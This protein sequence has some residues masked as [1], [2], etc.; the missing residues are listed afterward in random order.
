M[1][2]EYHLLEDEIEVAV[3]ENHFEKMPIE[4]VLSIFSFL[5]AHDLLKVR[6]VCKEWCNL[7]DD[8]VIWKNLVLDDWNIHT[9]LEKT[10]KE[11]YIRI[12]DLF[13]FGLW[14][15]MSKWI[16]PA[17][18]DNEQKTTAEL[19]FH[20]K[21][22]VG[23]SLPILRSPILKS[24]PS[25]IRR[26]DS[27]SNA[28]EK[29]TQSKDVLYRVRGSGITINCANPSPFQI[30]G[31]RV[32]SDPTGCTFQWSKHFEK[33]TSVYDGKIDLATNTVSG[34][35]DYNDGSTHWKGVFFYTKM[36]RSIQ[37]KQRETQ[38][39]A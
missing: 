39:I 33:H 35:I 30:D 27:A 36:K 15:G 29:P 12:Y 14:D 1:K 3:G 32:E 10:W 23:S 5:E 37:S 9:C 34:T 19:Q 24:S 6:L 28:M 8:D 4:A 38:V 22:R 25:A 7:A 16:E 20:K 11:T 31:E 18:Y 17:G 2:S 26:V 13:S 21:R